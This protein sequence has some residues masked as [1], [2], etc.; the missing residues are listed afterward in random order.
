MK[1]GEK[2]EHSFVGTLSGVL[3]FFALAIGVTVVSPRLVDP[4]WTEATSNYQVQIYEFGDPHFFI[5]N[6]VTGTYDLQ[7][8]A[9]IEEG[10]S[11]SAF[12]ETE[13]SRILASDELKPFVTK[14]GQ[15]LRLTDRVLLL[16]RPGEWL[17]DQVTV[18]E[19]ELQNNFIKHLPNWKERGM[20]LPTVDVFELY[21]PK[22]KEAFA[23]S[24]AEASLEDYADGHFEIIQP[25]KEHEKVGGLLY[26]K[27]PIEYRVREVE[28]PTGKGF[29]YSPQGRAIKSLLE[30]RQLGFW[31]RK[32]LIN[33]GETIYAY[34]GCW[35]CH[36]DQTRTLVQ[37]VVLNGSDSYP[38]PP[39][40]AS[41]YIYQNTTFPG[42][43]RI[44]PDISR[45]G[46][47]RPSRDW[48][49]SHFWSPKT[50]SPGSI[51]PSFQHFFDNDPRGTAEVKPGVPNLRFEAIY[52]YLMTKG[53]RLT[54]P[55]QAWWLGKDPIQTK[56]IIEGER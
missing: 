16:R 5:S 53:T 31:S 51:M 9:W 37:D 42:T 48:H 46:V 2:V 33:L 7:F 13:R 24:L 21:D 56:T 8:V 18:L 19:K 55:S 1:L 32:E 23:T 11:L 17:Q 28:T 3:V 6:S 50:A 45:T 54:A 44:G 41:E 34:E 12:V 38:A 49:R 15:P 36:T 47:K 4:T 29:R 14:V 39:S 40:S 20:A 10:K 22:V 25:L 30:L 35:Y 43:R 52:Q 26:V 27:N